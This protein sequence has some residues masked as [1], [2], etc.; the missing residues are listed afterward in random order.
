[1]ASR[2]MIPDI[3]AFYSRDG[4]L[5]TTQEN[6]EFFRETGIESDH[7]KL[8]N[9]THPEASKFRQLGIEVSF[10]NR[11]AINP[12]HLRSFAPRGDPWAAYRRSQY[13]ALLQTKP[14]WVHSVAP[15]SSNHAA[16]RQTCTRRL[17]YCARRAAELLAGEDPPIQ[18]RGTILIFVRDAI[19]AVNLPAQGFQ[20]MM[21]MALRK[22]MHDLKARGRKW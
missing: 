6:A 3:S 20:D 12:Y 9:L 10:S 5:T 18:V 7:G 14:L 11:Y 8:W 19:K 17:A 4:T 2:V 22:E 21:V 1:M 15:Y 13:K 16:V